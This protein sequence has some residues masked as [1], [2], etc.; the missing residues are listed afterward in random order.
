MVVVF[1]LRDIGIGLRIGI[2]IIYFVMIQPEIYLLSFILQLTRFIRVHCLTSGSSAWGIVF[3]YIVIFCYIVV[4]VTSVLS[5]P[6][7]LAFNWSF[8]GFVCFCLLGVGGQ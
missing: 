1:V 5:V 6:V 8:G 7:Q 4:F 3:P 2:A